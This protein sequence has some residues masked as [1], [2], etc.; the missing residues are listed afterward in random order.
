[1]GR[2]N[3]ANGMC[4]DCFKPQFEPSEKSK[5]M[6]SSMR[7]VL[8][9]NLGVMVVKMFTMGLAAGFQDAF[10]CMI[11]YCAIERIDYCQMLFYIIFNGQ[12]ALEIMVSLG[13]ALQKKVNVSAKSPPSIIPETRNETFYL[14]LSISML[15]FYIVSICMAFKS[16]REFKG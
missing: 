9:I 15:V 4:G 14:V 8:G 11:L 3:S 2:P 12:L 16:Y 7:I 6:M 5:G 13:F 10:S 1:M